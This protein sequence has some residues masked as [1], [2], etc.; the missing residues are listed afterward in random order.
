M[1]LLPNTSSE[2]LPFLLSDEKAVWKDGKWIVE[3]MV[4]REPSEPIEKSSKNIEEALLT[5]WDTIRKT[6]NA[7]L[8]M[9][10]WTALNDVNLSEEDKLAWKNF[11]QE[12]RDLPQK[13]EENEEN[14]IWPDC[15]DPGLYGEIHRLK[16]WE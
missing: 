15:P 10:D 14:L 8:K 6:R 11:R 3:K 5:E 16:V 2:E 12:L 1:N 13:F 4:C 7:V 9:T